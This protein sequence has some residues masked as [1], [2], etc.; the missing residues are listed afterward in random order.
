MAVS[1]IAVGAWHVC[2]MFVPVFAVSWEF[3][4]TFPYSRSSEP[5]VPETC[6]R[7][8]SIDFKPL[9]V[10]VQGSKC[11]SICCF[12]DNPISALQ[13]F[14]S[15]YQ[16]DTRGSCCSREET[17]SNGS[18]YS[19][20]M[21]HGFNHATG[22]HSLGVW[23]HNSLSFSFFAVSPKAKTQH[24]LSLSIMVRRYHATQI[25]C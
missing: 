19:K 9:G 6:T 4:C 12:D 10:L 21:V 23:V 25:Y 20:W 14:S 17:A 22:C 3:K 15:W 18:N 24:A 13:D 5:S 8:G 16:G 1:V 2:I 11:S 7:A